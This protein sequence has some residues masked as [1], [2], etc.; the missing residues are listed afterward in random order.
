[1]V[2]EHSLVEFLG[3]PPPAITPEQDTIVRAQ[4]AAR[5]PHDESTRLD[6]EEILLGKISHR[7]AMVEP[8]SYSDLKRLAA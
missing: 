8:L 6:L 5:Y 7:S 1:M 3:P 4:I 2:S